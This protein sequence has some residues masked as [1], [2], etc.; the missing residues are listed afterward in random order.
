MKS[1]RYWHGAIFPFPVWLIVALLSFTHIA[2]ALDSAAQ[3]LDFEDSAAR[4][5]R[6]HPVTHRRN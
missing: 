6:S 3:V 4:S 1:V 2:C 5:V